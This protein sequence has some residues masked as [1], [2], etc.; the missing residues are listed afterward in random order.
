MK[1][2]L[3]ALVLAA[4]AAVLGAAAPPAMLVQVGGGLWEV[5]RSANGSNPV[6]I[7]APDPVRLAQFE[8]RGSS[9]TRI[10][11]SQDREEAVIHYTCARGGFGQTRM[12]MITPRSLRLDTQ[13]ISNDL[14]FAYVLHARLVGSCNGR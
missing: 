7:C 6:R 9:C 10:I 3:S 5:S 14:P 1:R 13:G 8:H 2:L 12:T 11:V 4:A